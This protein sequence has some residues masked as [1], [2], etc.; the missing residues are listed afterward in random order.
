MALKLTKDP[1]ATN[2]P[3]EDPES[4]GNGNPGASN[5]METKLSGDDIPKEYQGKTVK[6]VFELMAATQGRITK[7]EQENAQWAKAANTP[8]PKQQDPD[9]K[10]PVQQLWDDAVTEFGEA[11]ANIIAGIAGARLAPFLTGITAIHKVMAKDMYADYEEFEEDIDRIV[12]NMTPE[13]LADP[14]YSYY[15]AY[16]AA[17]LGK[18]DFAPKPK[19]DVPKHDEGDGGVPKKEPKEQGL[20]PEQEKWRALQG[21]SKEEFLQYSTAEEM[22]EQGSL[23]EVE[24]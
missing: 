7:L 24:A 19:N 23:P 4:K 15:Y 8:A 18:T 12:Q 14:N 17:K 22:P 3:V 2:K 10:D 6:E 5:V 11:G 9:A 21:L 13:Q 16:K 1:D 20:T